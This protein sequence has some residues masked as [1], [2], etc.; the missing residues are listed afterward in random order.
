MA[1][2]TYGAQK[3]LGERA[4]IKA[5]NNKKGLYEVELEYIKEFSGTFTKCP[6]CGKKVL[7]LVVYNTQ[8]FPCCGIWLFHE[9]YGNIPPDI[10]LSSPCAF[11]VMEKLCDT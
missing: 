6:C 10:K 1:E 4:E 11:A 7:W 9:E 8:R 2:L 5:E 3:I